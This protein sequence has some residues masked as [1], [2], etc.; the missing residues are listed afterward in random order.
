M[1]MCDAAIYKQVQG[2]VRWACY[3]QVWGG[4]V[5]WY[6]VGCKVVLYRKFGHSC[7][8]RMTCRT[9]VGNLTCLSLG[10]VRWCYILLSQHVWGE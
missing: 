7:P 5:K 9:N 10:G 2:G 3:K 4:D 1:C 8:I 6:C